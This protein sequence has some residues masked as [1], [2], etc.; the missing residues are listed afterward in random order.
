MKAA[1]VFTFGLWLY[2]MSFAI[3]CLTPGMDRKV[4]VWWATSDD[5]PTSD[6]QM[7][8]YGRLVKVFGAGFLLVLVVTG[9]P[10]LYVAQEGETFLGI[11]A[12]GL[13][14]LF[15]VVAV[16]TLVAGVLKLHQAERWQ[17]GVRP[18]SVTPDELAEAEA[19]ALRMERSGR[20]LIRAG[21]VI[22]TVNYIALNLF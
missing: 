12:Q 10:S 2:A 9:L 1:G 17:R 20:W 3:R 15:A 11:E 18:E 6:L 5:R 4:A 19:Q 13:G 14:G 7:R 16:W 8:W 21:F 22:L